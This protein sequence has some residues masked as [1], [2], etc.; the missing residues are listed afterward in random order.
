MHKFLYIF[1]GMILGFVLDACTPYIDSRRQAGQ[2]ETVGQSHT[3][4]I[5]VC[6]NPIF[7][8]EN[9]LKSLALTECAPKDVVYQDTRYFNC[10]LF[11]PNTA[12]YRCK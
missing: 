5:A 12:F 10:S 9:E 7:S 8:D 4:N 2:I 6:Y 1:C 11:H 3:P